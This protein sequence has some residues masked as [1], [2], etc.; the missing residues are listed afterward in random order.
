MSGETGSQVSGWTIDT[1]KE[2]LA[3]LHLASEARLTAAITHAQDM[4]SAST[5]AAQNAI[6]KAE[7]A[8]AAKF[9]SVNEFRAALA[10]QAERMM[11][12]GESEN[13][14]SALQEKLEVFAHTAIL[15]S[16]ALTTRIDELNR[17]LLLREGAESG[18]K[19]TKQTSMAVL[20]VIV[21]GV[22]A[23]SGVLGSVLATI[24]RPMGIH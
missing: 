1:L 4:A 11:P 14:Y 13:R 18:S 23:L 24:M 16:E 7:A 17:R 15:R 9:A 22:G 20:A 5:R 10:D 19:E 12:R 21:A 6:D 8:T 2:H 3:E